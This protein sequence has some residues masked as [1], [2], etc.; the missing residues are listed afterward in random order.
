MYEALFIRHCWVIPVFHRFLIWNHWHEEKLA[1]KSIGREQL[2]ID[3]PWSTGF[4]VPRVWQLPRTTLD[5]ARIT[6][7]PMVLWSVGC[8]SPPRITHAPMVLPQKEEEPFCPSC[9]RTGWQGKALAVAYSSPCSTGFVLPGVWEL[10]KTTLCSN[11]FA[12]K[13]G[14]V[15]LHIRAH[16][17]IILEYI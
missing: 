4:V 5:L 8:D 17:E 6:L 15:C 2:P 10:P 11:G 9:M 1:R 14:G 7:A 3:N 13:G 12:T 16:P